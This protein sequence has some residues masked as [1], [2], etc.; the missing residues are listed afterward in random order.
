MSQTT[1]SFEETE[2]RMSEE[3]LEYFGELIDQFPEL[4][5][6]T[7]EDHRS[8]VDHFANPNNAQVRATQTKTGTTIRLQPNLW[9]SPQKTTI[10]CAAGEGPPTR[11]RWGRRWRNPSPSRRRTFSRTHRRG[12]R[13]STL[14]TTPRCLYRRSLQDER[15]PHAM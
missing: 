12:R 6:L 9:A 5:I 14:R 13:E 2:D 10:Q 15:V 4:T 7:E 11:K 8:M 3:Q 1:D